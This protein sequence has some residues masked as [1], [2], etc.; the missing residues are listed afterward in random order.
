MASQQEAGGGNATYNAAGNDVITIINAGTATVPATRSVTIQEPVTHLIAPLKASQ[1]Y[2]QSVTSTLL[3][4][5]ETLLKET[6]T[7]HL[8]SSHKLSL[9][10][11]NVARMEAEDDVNTSGKAGA[12]IPHLPL[13]DDSSPSGR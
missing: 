11:R 10:E 7:K 1:D 12:Q 4:G 3:P 2:I 8:D 9:K 6:S 13:G 5:L